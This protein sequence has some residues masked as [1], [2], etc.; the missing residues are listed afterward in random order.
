M[1]VFKYFFKIM[2]EYKGTIL[3]YTII[4]ILFTGFNMTTSENNTNFLATKPDILLIDND[5]SSLSNN[6]EK[7]LKE[8]AN[9]KEVKNN[10]DALFYRDVSLIIKI[11][12]GYSKN[13]KDIEIKSTKDS[14][15]EYGV[16][17]LERYLKV[18]NIYK[19]E[20][21]EEEILIEK[22]NESIKTNTEV[23]IKTTLDTNALDKATFF[24]NF[25]NYSLLA[26]CLFVIS[27]ILNNF[28]NNN[29]KK[30]TVISS[31]PNNKYN[32]NLFLA[33]ST[34][35][36]LLWILYTVIGIVILKDVMF[37]QSGLL[38]LIN[39]FVFMI[40]AVSISFL[41]GNL[42]NDKEALNGIVNVIALGSSF[43]CGAFVP[44]Q[45]LPDF[46]LKIAHILPSYWFIKNNEIIKEIEVISNSSLKEYSFNIIMIIIFII[47]I[48]IATNIISKMKRKAN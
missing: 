3:L 8:Y 10:N 14:E 33:G 11:P 41:M 23:D 38:Y 22:I 6:L 25:A 43:L 27:I 45:F 37:T 21:L 30:R 13:E 20:N 40:C 26:G 4:L 17:L 46:V 2:K 44:M 16:M 15:A 39:S 12:K 29:I 34:Y 48:S 1:T 42:I 31:Y 32:R 24:Y 7:Y 28:K 19:K 5:N 9:L 18:S 36:L 35:G 47:I